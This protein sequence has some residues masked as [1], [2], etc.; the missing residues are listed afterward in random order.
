[1]NASLS[2]QVIYKILPSREPEPRNAITRDKIRDRDKTDRST[3]AP[4]NRQTASLTQ[5]SSEHCVLLKGFHYSRPL[6]DGFATPPPLSL[7]SVYS[8]HEEIKPCVGIPVS[9]FFQPKRE[10]DSSAFG[11]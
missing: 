9:F 5:P 1:M 6:A 7:L 4:S 2:S 10:L 8:R 3:L 11:S